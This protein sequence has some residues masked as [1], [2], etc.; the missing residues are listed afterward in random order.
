MAACGDHVKYLGNE[1]WCNFSY[2]S[3]GFAVNLTNLSENLEV[4]N[5]KLIWWHFFEKNHEILF[6]KNELDIY[7]LLSV[8]YRLL[9]IQRCKQKTANYKVC[10]GE[11]I[12][13]VIFGKNAAKKANL[14][15]WQRTKTAS[16]Q[17]G[18]IMLIR[19]AMFNEGS[20]LT[21]WCVPN[22]SV[23]YCSSRAV[24]TPPPKKMP[25]IRWCRKKCGRV[26]QAQV[27]CMLLSKAT[28]AHSEYRTLTAFPQQQW[29]DESASV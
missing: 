12:K 13:G 24:T 26:R 16:I 25:F 20:V 8:T 29:F 10:W 19:A 15:S 6:H 4:T 7:K 3:A 18:I 27:L 2:S 9:V 5:L 11:P 23:R 14:N 17:T 22:T 28:E 1:N 21:A